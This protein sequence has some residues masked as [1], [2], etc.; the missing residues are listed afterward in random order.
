MLHLISLNSF[1]PKSRAGP[2]LTASLVHKLRYAGAEA[3]ILAPRP[4]ARFLHLWLSGVRL[5]L[6]DTRPARLP[7][8]AI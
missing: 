7:E 3:L 6:K 4:V 1:A 5:N 8:Y 2:G